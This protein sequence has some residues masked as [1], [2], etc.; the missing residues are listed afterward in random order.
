MFCLQIL[1]N[2]SIEE[3]AQHMHTI[4]LFLKT[5]FR[6]LNKA[7]CGICNKKLVYMYLLP[8][9]IWC[10]DS[11]KVLFQIRVT[12]I[13]EEGLKLTVDKVFF[14]FSLHRQLSCVDNEL[15]WRGLA[16]EE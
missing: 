11:K 7:L 8:E 6:D 15:D 3:T 4:R 14:F 1:S 13:L 5:S 2:I 9:N 10:Q 16:V 12:F